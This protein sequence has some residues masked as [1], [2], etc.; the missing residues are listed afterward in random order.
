MAG[1]P[2]SSASN[3]EL[4]LLIAREESLLK[5]FNT[6]LN[7]LEEICQANM[8]LTLKQVLDTHNYSLDKMIAL[9][10]EIESRQQPLVI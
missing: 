9:R 1:K 8:D 6:L 2:L 3:I 10:K 7:K 4:E 5:S